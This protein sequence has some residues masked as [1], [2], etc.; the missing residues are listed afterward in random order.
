[1]SEQYLTG[2]NRSGSK[3]PST[4]KVNFKTHELDL[5]K[6]SD[7]SLKSPSPIQEPVS[8]GADTGLAI[9]PR[10]KIVHRG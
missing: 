6:Y 2:S 1:M 4:I 8:P 10:K 9:R 3:S 7:A 5:K